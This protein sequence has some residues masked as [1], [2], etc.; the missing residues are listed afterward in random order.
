[1]DQSLLAPIAD[2][3]F[4]YNCRQ[5]LTHA[6]HTWVSIATLGHQPAT[7]FQ[8]LYKCAPVE[9]C[10][11]ALETRSL[12]P[13]SAQPAAPFGSTHSLRQSCPLWG[14]SA[15]RSHSPQLSACMRTK[16]SIKNRLSRNCLCLMLLQASSNMQLRS[17]GMQGRSKLGR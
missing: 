10:T 4:S 5:H 16:A 12:A 15:Q 3:C 8:H 14:L 11:G 2:C 6:A 9:H 1:M 7:R 13:S 17:M